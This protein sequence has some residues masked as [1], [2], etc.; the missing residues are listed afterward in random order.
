MNKPARDVITID[1]PS[2]SG[3]GTI[4]KILA[5]KL[6]YTY[7]DT[8]A[9]YRA[10]VWKAKRMNIDIDR[11]DELSKILGDIGISMQGDRLSVNGID[12]TAAIRTA[13]MGELSSRVSAL[14]AVREALFSLQREIC[15]KGKVVIEGRDTGS[16]IFPESGNKFYLD[17]S[18]EE[19]AR[20]R[21]EDLKH[22]D[23]SVT[24]ASTKDDLSKRDLRDAGRAHAPLVRTDDMTYI[25]STDLSIDQV[26]EEILQ[27]LR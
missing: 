7:L 4:A 19:R 5:G 25:D 16:V 23:P 27:H 24:L 10:V 14:P 15:M 1:G 12:V 21:Y 8:G 11:P 17:A 13:E 3:K 26:V 9:L 20:R 22:K 18:I 2:G 6:G